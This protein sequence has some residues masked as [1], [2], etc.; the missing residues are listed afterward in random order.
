MRIKKFIILPFIFACVIIYSYSAIHTNNGQAFSISIDLGMPLSIVWPFEVAV[1]GDNGEKGSRIGPKIGRGWCGEAGGEASYKFYVPEDGKYH[2]WAYCLWFD[3]CANAVF[4]QIDDLDKAVVGNDPI[5]NK[6]HW[7]R[8]FDVNLKKG[9][10]TLVLSNHSDHISLQKILFTNST[11]IVPEQCSLVFSDIFYDGFDGCDQGNFTSW[12]VVRGEWVVQNPTDQM[13]FIEN[14]LIGKSEGSSF[15]IYKSDVWSDYSLNMAVKSIPSE[16]AEAAIGICF[17]VKENCYHQLIL[18]PIEGT[19]KAKV[20]I[21]RK[22]YRETQVLANFEVPWQIDIWHQVE[23]NLTENNISVKVDNTK[24]IE[25][26]VSY[27]ITGGI[28]LCLEGRIT[29]CFDDIHVRETGR[30]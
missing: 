12:E 18:R 27:K 29:A 23:I 4:A 7:V 6:W 13:C 8:G 14:A 30:I 5:Y 25:M 22:T 20:E 2:I 26:P 17:G 24:P 21:C 3:E 28:G 9:T 16:D 11:S 10:H 19:D 15:I 1:V